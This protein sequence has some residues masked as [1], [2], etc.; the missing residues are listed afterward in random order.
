MR[1]GGM[2]SMAEEPLGNMRYFEAS[3][4]TPA[5][6]YVAEDG[7]TFYVAEDGTTY[8]VQEA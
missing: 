1:R 5:N 8:Y 3:A 4:S 7:T 6:A 2:D